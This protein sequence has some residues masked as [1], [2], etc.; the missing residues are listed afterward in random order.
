MQEPRV[1]FFCFINYKDRR[2]FSGTL[3]YMRQALAARKEMQ[4]VDLGNPSPPSFWEK[5]QKR[6]RKLTHTEK[7]K[8]GSPRYQAKYK[9]FVEQ[10]QQQ[11]R[12]TPC[13]IIFAPAASEELSFFST[14][15]PIIYLSD[16][17]FKLFN[18]DY[19]VNFEP[20]EIEWRDRQE[21]TAISKARQLIYSSEWAANSAIEDYQADPAKIKI[22]PFGANLED[23]P[24]ASDALSRKL[25][26]P[27]R[28]LFV[29]RN[30]YRKGGEIA[31]QTLSHLCQMGVDAEL[32][33]VGTT[34]PE[35]MTHDQVR[36]IPYINK[37][38]PQQR[39]QLEQ[40][41]L[42]SHFFI[43]PTRADCSP[44]VVC[45]ASAY[46]L[47]IL[48]AE[49]GGIPTIVEN[50][51]NGYMLPL[52]ASGEDYA[53]LIAEIVSDSTRYNQLVHSSRQEYDSRLNWER[54]AES[55]S[56]IVMNMAH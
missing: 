13:D 33:V 20:Q 34:P 44:I 22:I 12:K 30:W 49:V 29:G 5:V 31:F 50:G 53:K 9:K 14:D 39:Q 43:F 24:A 16:T 11:L 3:Y 51:K 32:V 54:W 1:G 7:P 25:A 18:Q 28:L 47:P 8:I 17:T 35:E 23:P 52:S 37:N 56:E 45:E 27:C 55:F 6:I 15:L 38:D 41:F 21:A 26:S 4:I 10:V 48:T 36:V 46:G 40:L 42:T 2:V 19:E